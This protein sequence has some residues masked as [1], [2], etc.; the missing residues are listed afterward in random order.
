L[1]NTGDEWEGENLVISGTPKP[2]TATSSTL[3]I[4]AHDRVGMEVTGSSSSKKTK[5]LT[6]KSERKAR[7]N[8]ILLIGVSQASSGKTN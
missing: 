4:T 3:R 7:L 6:S 8:E 1:E 2:P 5:E